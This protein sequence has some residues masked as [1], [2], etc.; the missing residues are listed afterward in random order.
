MSLVAEL[1]K[2]RKELAA[3]KARNAELEAEIVQLRKDVALFKDALDRILAGKTK[4]TEHDLAQPPL[5]FLGE[6]P[7]LEVPEHLNEASDGETAE[8]VIKKRNRPKKTSKRIDTS[9]L[10]R[11]DVIHELPPEDRICPDTGVPLAPIGETVSEELVYTKAEYFVRNHR[12]IIYGPSPEVAKDRQIATRT[13]PLPV[14]PLD[15]CLASASFLAWLLASK[16]RCHLPLYRLE[17]ILADRG[18]MIP[19]ARLCDWVLSS[20]FLLKPI[21]DA[22]LDAI[23]A[24][25][26]TQLDDTPV[27]CQ[28]EKGQ[29][30]FEARLWAYINPEV[31]GVGYAF[32]SGR[33]GKD[34]AQIIAGS[35]GYLVGDGLAAQKKAAREAGDLKSCGCWAHA[36]RYFRDSVNEDRERITRMLKLMGRLFTLEEEAEKENVTW[37]ERHDRRQAKNPETLKAIFAEIGAWQTYPS[38]DASSGMGKAF[39]YLNNQWATL[40]QFMEDGRVPIHNNACE[41]AIRSLAIGRKNWLFAG[42]VRGGE[43]AAILFT[44]VE[45]CKL[46]GV[47]PEDY[48]HDV[49]IR[50]RSQ[51][52]ERMAELLPAAWSNE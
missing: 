19:R 1:Q 44:L 20:A 29:G 51:P 34:A 36:F 40:V 42:S 15:N 26:I 11:E 27:R 25:P 43:A 12:T 41:R 18:L 35:S 33:G 49:L 4:R 22:M 45:S 47:S 6:E 13:A 3:Q 37:T 5:P 39:T 16:Y 31:E 50:V 28:G 7:E 23:R 38:R 8:D 21:A 2:E 30:M 48:F 24:G 9:N 32:T 14:R 17:S 10:K 46:A 52:L